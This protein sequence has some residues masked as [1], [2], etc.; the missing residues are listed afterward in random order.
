MQDA[1]RILQFCGNLCEE[2]MRSRGKA[3]SLI[4]A[5]AGSH[6]SAFIRF[7]LERLKWQFK[8]WQ[9]LSRRHEKPD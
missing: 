4:F 8:N 6:R 1:I 2:K 5:Q 7:V 9:L 3:A